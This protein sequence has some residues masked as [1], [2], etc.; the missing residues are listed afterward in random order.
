MACLRQA[1]HLVDII[2]FTLTHVPMKGGSMGL[3][4]LGGGIL[5]KAWDYTG[6]SMPHPSPLAPGLPGSSHLDPAY[7]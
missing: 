7:S 3:Q 2:S 5:P 1:S 4:G 6:H